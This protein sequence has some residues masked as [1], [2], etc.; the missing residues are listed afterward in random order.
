VNTSSLQHRVRSRFVSFGLW[1]SAF[2]FFVIEGYV[3]VSGGEVP[4]IFW[5]RT[6][7][8]RPGDMPLVGSRDTFPCMHSGESEKCGQPALWRAVRLNGYVEGPF[9]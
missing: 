4:Y 2:A 7:E 9:G 5:R 1:T 6:G 8:R 3:L